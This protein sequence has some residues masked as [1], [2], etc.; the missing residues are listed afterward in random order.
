MIRAWQIILTIN[1]AK[2]G[3]KLYTTSHCIKCARNR[4][5]QWAVSTIMDSMFPQNPRSPTPFR[6]T[7]G[8][9]NSKNSEYV[10]LFTVMFFSCVLLTGCF[11]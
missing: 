7:P 10:A 9:T 3:S 1:K 4:Y 8:T 11:L 6:S 5:I 2:R